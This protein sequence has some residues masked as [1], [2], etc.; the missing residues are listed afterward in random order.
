MQ[1]GTYYFKR[2]VFLY[3]TLK[4]GGRCALYMIARGG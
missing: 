4:Q 2:A 3:S 1:W